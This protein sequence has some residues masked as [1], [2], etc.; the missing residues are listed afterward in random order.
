MALQRRSPLVATSLSCSFLFLLLFSVVGPAT[1]GK[2]GQ[3]TVF[4]GRNR[5]T[6]D[7]GLYTTVIIS[8]LSVFGHG[9]Y[10]L[11]ISGHDASAVGA[12]VKHCRSMHILP[13]AGHHINADSLL[14][15]L[16]LGLRASL[17]SG[18]CDGDL[19]ETCGAEEGSQGGE[20]KRG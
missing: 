12:D 6:C 9:K 1:A 11:D 14:R 8:F 7:T 20:Q 18:Y 2:T 10:I 17:E 13:H 4:W 5:E 3:P 16:G 19:H 15:W